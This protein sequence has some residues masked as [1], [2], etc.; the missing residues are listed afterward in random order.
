MGRSSKDANKTLALAET[1][2]VSGTSIAGVAR[3][4]LFGHV[5]VLS[6]VESNCMH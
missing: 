3:R 6:C 2:F 5:L 1:I 4:E